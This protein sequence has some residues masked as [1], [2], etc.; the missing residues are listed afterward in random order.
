MIDPLLKQVLV[1]LRINRFY[2][3]GTH[4]GQ[5]IALVAGWF[6]ELDPA[7]GRITGY[8]E[9]GLRD[10]SKPE[11]PVTYPDFEDSGN[12]RFRIQSVDIDPWSVKTAS[13]IFR[14]N[15]NIRIT[16]D[17]SADFIRKLIPEISASGKSDEY[18][19]YLDAHWGLT[20]PLR[21]EITSIVQLERF[22]L[23]VD[24]FFV[25]GKSSISNPDG[26]FGF[27]FYRQHV[28]QWAYIKDLFEVHSD[29]IR[30]FYPCN[31]NPDDRGWVLVVAGYSSE[32]LAKLEKLPLFS[33]GVYSEEHTARQV[34]PVRVQ[35][36]I[37][38][39]FKSRTP[40]WILRLYLRSLNMR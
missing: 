20:L 6:A 38:N 23:V 15:S 16:Q 18:F 39:F 12:S 37:K 28:L 32:V 21:E 11:R 8:S 2:E 10:H 9:R 4:L 25:P 31:P 14:N 22:A 19:F 24:D 1:D 13:G 35:L 26:A 27:D 34:V 30:I 36:G 33:L 5:T 3:T 7:F 40:L 29:R 17:D